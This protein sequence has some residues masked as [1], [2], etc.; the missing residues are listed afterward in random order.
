MLKESLCRCPPPSLRLL[1]CEIRSFEGLYFIFPSVVFS[2]KHE[3]EFRK[4]MKSLKKKDKEMSRTCFSFYY[5]YI[6]VTHQVL[7]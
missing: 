5:R 3:K 6:L 7:P 1:E 4:K 2:E